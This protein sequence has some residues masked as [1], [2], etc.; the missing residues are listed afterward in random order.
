MLHVNVIVFSGR[1]SVGYI[2]GEIGRAA[3][4]M[5]SQPWPMLFLPPIC[6]LSSLALQRT[7]TKLPVTVFIFHARIPYMYMYN[8]RDE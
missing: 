4:Y 8:N 6:S 5:Y 3:I 2:A 1:T 7:V